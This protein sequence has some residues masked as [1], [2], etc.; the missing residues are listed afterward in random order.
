[1]VPHLNLAFNWQHT[2]VRF[3]VVPNRD[4]TLVI[5]ATTPRQILISKLAC[6]Y[7][8]PYS[9]YWDSLNN[10]V[11]TLETGSV[12]KE[13][14]VSSIDI[15]G[16]IFSHALESQSPHFKC[17]QAPEETLWEKNII[18]HIPRLEVEGGWGLM[19]WQTPV[20]ASN[21]MTPRTTQR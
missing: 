10:H 9:W 14:R 21:D 20:I 3:L 17:H 4:K 8:C 16:E 12:N 5:I 7:S 19:S 2:Y 18:V 15:N 6:P 13:L 1:M 11:V